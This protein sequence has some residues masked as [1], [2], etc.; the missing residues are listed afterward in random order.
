E[1]EGQVN[2]LLIARNALAGLNVLFLG[3]NLLDAHYLWAGSPPHTMTTQ[4][5]AHQGAFWLTVALL[6]VTAIVGIMFRGGLA[7]ADR[8]RGVRGMAYVWMLQGLVLGL[9]T[10]RRIAIHIAKSGLA[11]LRIVGILRTRL[12]LGGLMLGA[13]K[14]RHRRSF[15]WLLR[16][17]LD[18]FAITVV[19]YGITP[20]HL[21]SA[22]VNV[23]RVSSGE[24]RPIL[25]AFRQSHEPESTAT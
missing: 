25:H 5:Y 12:V 23:A 13:W 9:G 22:R 21:L 20:T 10:Y 15:A 16:R 19:L 3:Y 1:P 17:Q 18:A 11:D 6:M 4:E 8:A 2:A 14:L 24:Y 7:E